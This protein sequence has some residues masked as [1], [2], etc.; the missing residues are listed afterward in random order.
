ME[1]YE[2]LIDNAI[3]FYKDSD[4]AT[5]TFSQRRYITKIKKL[6]EKYPNDCKIIEEGNGGI[7]ARIP[8]SW[9]KISPKRQVSEEQRQKSAERLAKARSGTTV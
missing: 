1:I 2:G 3:E 5:V 8:V 9:V 7:Y 6:A 4:I